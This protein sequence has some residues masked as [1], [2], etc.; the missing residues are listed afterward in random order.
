MLGSFNQRDIEGSYSNPVIDRCAKARISDGK[1][2]MY[3]TPHTEM[4]TAKI[5]AGEKVKPVIYLSG[6]LKYINTVTLK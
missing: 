5:D 4:M 6:S 3:K 2:P 1:I